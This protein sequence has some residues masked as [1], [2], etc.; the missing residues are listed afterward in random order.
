MNLINKILVLGGT[1]AMGGHL[2]SILAQQCN[3]QIF[4]TSRR[5]HESTGNVHYICGNAMNEVFLRSIL[6]KE[7]FFSIIDF[8][9]YTTEQF[10]HILPLLLSST[11][12]YIY[13]S[14]CRCY[15]NIDKSITETTPRLLDVCRDVEY[16]STDEYAL[17]KG[18]EEDLLFKSD[19]KN[20]TIIRPYI[21]YS[22]NRLQLGA[23]EKEEWL[24]RALHGRSI[25]FSEDIAKKKT[26]LTYG[27][28]VAMVISKLVG[29]VN[30]LGETFQITAD[31]SIYWSDVVDIY[32]D[33]IR[34]LTGRNVCVVM[35][36]KAFNLRFPQRKW[37]ILYDRC[38]NRIFDN[39]KVK[40]VLGSDYP[41]FTSPEIGLRQC[42]RSF[43]ANPKYNY[44]DWMKEAMLDRITKEYTPLSEIPSLKQK[45]KYIL[46][47]FLK[48]EFC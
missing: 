23:F 28:D 33:E 25:V 6:E 31:K 22:E 8:M 15:S 39:T 26:T 35:Q 41:S 14:S 45:V 30:S 2:V 7:K 18:R 38:Y 47:R 1:G 37:Q 46:Y 11:D 40:N 13:I 5:P 48:N 20:W 17:F 44:V 32:V 24:Y 9:T 4:V 19:L 36:E 42:I 34:N 3:Y 43:I 29:N 16:L 27:K 12:Q 21:T 10:K